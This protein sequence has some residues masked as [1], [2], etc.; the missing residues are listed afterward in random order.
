MEEAGK[1]D[2][3]SQVEETQAPEAETWLG[4]KTP[5]N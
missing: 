2:V 3:E 1:Q 5:K 4:A